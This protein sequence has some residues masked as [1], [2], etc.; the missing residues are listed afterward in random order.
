M[1]ETVRI[2]AFGVKTGD[3]LSAGFKSSGQRA[4]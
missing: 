1:E 4:G 3:Q 2:G